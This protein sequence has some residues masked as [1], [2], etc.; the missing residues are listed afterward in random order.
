[1]PTLISALRHRI[2]KWLG[3]PVIVDLSPY[4]ARLEQVAERGR[5]IAGAG[6][7]ELRALAADLRGRAREG[8][9]PGELEV[10]TFALGREA[11]RRTLGL[12][13]FDEQVLAGLAMSEG[14]LVE[15]QT[16]EGKTLAATLP[17]SLHALAGR[18]VHV[19]TFND[20]L[21]RR[22]ASW[23]GPVYGFLGLEVGAVQEGMPP[24]ER[25]RAYAA[26][27]T[28]LTAKEAGFDFL[29]DGLCLERP[30]LVQRPYHFA[31]V[32][33]ADSLLIDEAR[34]PLVIAG[35]VE[36]GDSS[37]RL[38]A[39]I[40]SRLEPGRHY[41]TDEYGRNVD[42]TE[43]GMERAEALLSRGD[44]V[45]A[46]NLTALTELNCALHAAVL[47]RRDVDYIVRENRIELV[48]E[49]TG[50]VVK[51]R[52][53]PDGLQAALE[54]KEG[55]DRRREGRTLGSITLQH[56]LQ[57]YP[58]L[59]GMTG[60]A[61]TAAEELGEFYG[62]DVVVIPTHR[63]SIR[64]D[65]PD[66]VF[67]HKGA[68]TRA[69]VREI[70][71]VHESGRPVL[72]GTVSVA[73]SERLAAALQEAGISCSVLNAKNDELEA[74][75][76]ARAGA[77]GAVTISTNMAGRGTD[78][79]L[80]G[81]DGEERERVVA[82][83]GLYVIGTNRHESERVDRQL[84]GRAGRQGDPGST[85]FFV[86][87][88]DDL[89]ARYGVE[90]LV[91]R[92]RWPALRDAPLDDPVI[93]REIARAQRIVEGQNFEIR[94]TLCRYS[95]Q[96]ER[97]RRKVQQRREDALFERS[98]PTLLAGAEPE[99][100]T[101]LARRHGEEA[102]YRAERQALVFH[103]DRLW[104]EQ[105][106]VIAD[107]REGIHLSRVG[108]RDPLTEFTHR[109]VELFRQMQTR[110]E[111]DVVQTLR[112]AEVGDTGIDLDREGLRGPSSTWTYLVNDDPFR[113]QLG[114]Q[115]GMS[116]G[117]AAAAALYTGPLLVLWGLYN[118]YFRRRRDGT[119][120]DDDTA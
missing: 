77:P 1:M 50:R 107:L 111:E 115:L 19:L 67:T 45:A 27:L 13:P 49:F 6:D 68:K 119:R 23:M 26:D 52:H 106:G 102:V 101:A 22:D 20:Y 109:A 39:R 58:R 72:V 94:R 90:R 63:P 34:S 7:E 14:R 2:A 17:A 15:M 46:E 105:L 4:R 3:D 29:R 99:R 66:L 30:D 78:I 21:A 11:S 56:F 80:G 81:P 28:Y 57:L 100:F 41:K 9:A 38:M 88:E 18:G 69:L 53:W 37:S 86:S 75:I 59:T 85:R 79:R 8:V 32:D 73:E 118:R 113:D 54:A 87:L 48:D 70:R 24:A 98:R 35:G 64:R 42:L 112:T 61:R 60:T 12:W 114:I 108:G 36:R 97:Q 55:L 40:V 104:S 95:D 82:L 31:L 74:G 120:E 110:I 43:R 65:L 96:V 51:D 10:E 44:L 47:L 25:R 93:R 5:R 76:V 117:Y 89:L 71:R 92:K 84:R 91:P 83:G 116:V 33:E 103:I 62:L 16:G